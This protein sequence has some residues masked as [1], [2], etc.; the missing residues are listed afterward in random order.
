MEATTAP[1]VAPVKIQFDADQPHQAAAIE[2]VLGLFRGQPL[3]ASPLDLFGLGGGVINEFGLRN[4]LSLAERQIGANLERI[5]EDNAIPPAARGELDEGGAPASLDFSV[6]METGTGK[7]YVYLR[8]IFELNRLYGFTKFVIVVPSV[9]IREGVEA[10]IRLLADHFAEL[11]DGVH[12]DSWVYDSKAPS[13]LRSF[14]QANYLQLMIINIDSFNRPDVNLIFRP[15]DQMMGEAPIEFLRAAAPIAILDEPQNM[16]SEIAKAA[17]ADLHP[18]FTLRYSATHLHSYHQVYRL[19]PAAAYNLGLVKQIEVW[20]VLEDENANRPYVRLKQVKAGKRSISAQIE[21]D[22]AAPGGVRRKTVSFAMDK[23]RDLREVAGRDVYDGYAIAE[24]RTGEVEFE[25][26]TTVAEGQA[27]GADRDHVQRVQIRTAVAQHLD[28]ELEMR[29]RVSSGEIAPL[30]VLSLFF[31]DRVD[32]YWPADGKFRVWF[33][34]EYERLAAMPKYAELDLPAADSVHGGYFARDRSGEAR[35]TRGGSLADAEAYELIMRDKQRLLSI[36]EPLRFIF[37]HSAL[38]EGWDNPN[39]FVITTLNEGR[40]ELRKRQEIGR[41]LRLPVMDNG[42]RCLDPSVATLSVVANES[43]VEFA[44]EL[45]REIEDETGT[46]F[47]RGNI[48][49]GRSR[50]R[51]ELRRGYDA[52]PS[53]LQLWDRISA[54]TRYRVEYDTAALVAAAVERLS[55]QPKLDPSFVRAT[56][57][58]VEMDEATGVS[59]AVIGEK[60]PVRISDSFPI[61]DL[62]SHLSTLLP[63][64][65]D[66]ISKVLKAS[67]RLQ[68]A[69]I[70]PQQFIDQARDSIE[71]ALAEQMVAGIEYTQRRGEGESSYDPGLFSAAELT[72]YEE[73]L[74]PVRK[75]IYTD[76][77]VDSDLER[78]I[79][80]A[81]DDREDVVFFI[82]LPGWFVVETP[83]GSYNPD[84]AVVKSGEDGGENVCLVRESKPSRDLNVLRPEERLKIRFGEK[85]FAAVGVEFDVIDDPSQI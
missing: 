23:Q 2:A 49:E 57:A 34:E 32:N 48:K 24:I 38:R 71:G 55:S 52:D 69:A 60:A 28:R 63:V 26:G 3:A 40:G 59:G 62:L 35:D 5:Q 17:L 27:I 39:I 29:R 10:S 14:A 78:E 41:G 43:Y 30:K 56:H 72:G 66:T 77:V 15:Q 18:L 25:N 1:G 80:K 54:R 36:A 4:D 68:E 7:T 74:V 42:L 84:W 58:A 12:Y 50:R 61:P 83:I 20:S 37:S 76:V 31:I 67:G 16:E 75:S 9:A 44:S 70:N 65:R 19:T 6:E 8:T 13:R 45:Q 11:Y 21:L 79:A 33:E 85:H 64:S 22:V 47:E 81:L 73:N 82:K 46:Q 53:F 51:I